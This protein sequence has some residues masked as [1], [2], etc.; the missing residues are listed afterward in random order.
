MSI[1]ANC[2]HAVSNRGSKEKDGLKFEITLLVFLHIAI[3]TFNVDMHSGGPYLKELRTMALELS[4]I[5]AS[6]SLSKFPRA[7]RASLL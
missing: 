6:N 1:S 3:A 5:S 2:Q 7:R 4:R